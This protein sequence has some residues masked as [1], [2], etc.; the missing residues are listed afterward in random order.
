MIPEAVALRD[1]DLL[2]YDSGES[3]TVASVNTEKNEKLEIKP[4][5]QISC[6]ITFVLKSLRVQMSCEM[7]HYVFSMQLQ[8]WLWI[9]TA[10]QCVVMATGVVEDTQWITF[11]QLTTSEDLTTATLT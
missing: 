11:A 5:A 3:G 7:G 8:P 9:L 4:S 2:R 6:E 10:G 1:W